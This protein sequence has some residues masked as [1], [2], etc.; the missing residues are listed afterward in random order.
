MS[1]VSQSQSRLLKLKTTA[2]GPT[3][4]PP[5]AIALLVVGLLPPLSASREEF[6]SI[7]AWRAWANAMMA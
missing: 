6:R 5:F 3:P 1:K 4:C 2:T 7:I